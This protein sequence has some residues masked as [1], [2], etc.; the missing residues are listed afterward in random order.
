MD[1]NVCQ[2]VANNGNTINLSRKT[3]KKN[4]F[5]KF[6]GKKS[7]SPTLSSVTNVTLAREPLAAI[8]LGIGSNCDVN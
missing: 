8:F 7:T 6:S 2:F 5:S 4:I 1:A 3:R